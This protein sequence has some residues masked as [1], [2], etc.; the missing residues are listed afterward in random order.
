MVQPRESTPPS[1]IPP[2]R[3]SLIC[4]VI[5]THTDILLINSHPLFSVALR[6]ISPL[7]MRKLSA[8][9]ITHTT[10]KGKDA[11]IKYTCVSTATPVPNYSTGFLN[12]SCGN[13]KARRL[14]LPQKSFFPFQLPELPWHFP[15]L[16]ASKD[17]GLIRVANPII[18]RSVCNGPNAGHAAAH[19]VDS[20]PLTPVGLSASVVI[21]N[22]WRRPSCGL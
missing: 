20:R 2:L 15:G 16:Q 9:N 12:E 6:N 8:R 11:Q 3:L 19:H 14:S 7:L 13:A 22:P 4:R 21:R 17:F 18:T 1:D 5:G 10:E